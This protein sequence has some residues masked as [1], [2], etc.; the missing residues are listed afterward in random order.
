MRLF[1]LAT[2]AVVACRGEEVL[3][4]TPC[5]L[6]TDPARYHHRLVEVAGTVSQGFEDFT[7][8]VPECRQ[9]DL[10]QVWLEYGGR[11]TSKVVYCCG[12]HN[13]R[14]APLVVDGYKTS[15][16]ED[17]NYRYFKAAV[18]NSTVEAT[19]QGRFFARSETVGYGHMGFF[20][21][22]VIQ[23]IVT[24]APSVK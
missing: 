5:E 17:K 16:V 10:F 18:R 22:L 15:F 21:L 1:L 24:V 2:L 13:T 11:A 20:H 12:N 7:F 9:K 6:S 3:R 4:V 8:A 23:R 19:L 14:R